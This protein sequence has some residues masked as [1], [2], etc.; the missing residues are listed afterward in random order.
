MSKF[1]LVCGLLNPRLKA[2][3]SKDFDG[4]TAVIA[5]PFNRYLPNE[6]PDVSNAQ[7]ADIAGKICKQ[8]GLAF[9]GQGEQV[10][11]L[12]SRVCSVRYRSQAGAWVQ[13]HVLVRWI[14]A[15]VLKLGKG[16]TVVLVG[17][18]HHVRRIS[19]LARYYRLNPL[20]SAR[21]ESVPYDGSDRE[22]AQ[23]WCKSVWRYIP[24][25]YASR[26]VLIAKLLMGQI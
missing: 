12:D 4:A 14:A 8:V 18:P 24:W 5:A 2:M 26:A 15:E 22:G 9:L 19:L 10:D 3:Y 25:E 17:H 21:C 13:T 11:I 20:V 6:T 23:W 7:I 16:S 1:Q